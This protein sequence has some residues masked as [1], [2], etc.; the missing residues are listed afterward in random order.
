V[1]LVADADRW[2]MPST[3]DLPRESIHGWVEE[4]ALPIGCAEKCQ[5]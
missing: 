5:G 2:A 1:I 4:Q 3:L